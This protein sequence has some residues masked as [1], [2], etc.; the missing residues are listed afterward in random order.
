M[1]DYLTKP[2]NKTVL[3]KLIRSCINSAPIVVGLASTGPVNSPSDSPEES[4]VEL[5][6]GER[7]D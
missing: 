2:L 3:L 4:S 6:A 1:T 7:G 5:G